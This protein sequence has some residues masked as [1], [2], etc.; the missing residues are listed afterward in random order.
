MN[1]KI[2]EIFKNYPEIIDSP[3]EMIEANTSIIIYEGQ[4]VIK[5][6]SQEII[7]DGV[8]QFDWFPN[9]GTSFYGKPHLDT[10]TLFKIFNGIDDFDVMLDG[11]FFGKGLL[12]NTS[13]GN[14][15]FI[16]GILSQ[17]AIKGDKSIAVQK[18][19]FSI[20]NLRDFLGISVKRVTDKGVNFSKNR[21]LLD[22]DNYTI[23]IDKCYNYEEL[24]QSLESKGGY[25]IQYAGELVSKKGSIQIDDAKDTLHCLDTF[26]SFLN[27]RRTSALFIH[28][29]YENETIWCD[30]TDYFVDT[31]KSNFSWPQKHS[32]I[33]INEL[34]QKF[35]DLWKDSDDKGFL[36]SAIHWYIEANSNSGFAEGSIIMAQTALELIYNWLIIE[37]K[38]ILIGKD[39]ENICAANKLRLILSH[40]NIDYN[41]PESFS[42]LQSFI[43]VSKDIIDAPDAVVQ[44]RNAIVHSQEEK[45]KK[46]S[47]IHYK[48]KYEALQL[49]IWYIEMSLLYILNFDDKYYNRCVRAIHMIDSEQFVPWTRKKNETNK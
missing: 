22:N 42:S 33:G 41:V 47:S 4:F 25:I 20:P 27:G 44:I 1:N 49:C 32:I 26:L 36:I 10:V 5:K 31:Y 13:F 8:I 35:S 39:S 18:L 21:L 7:I 24:Q 15:A 29:I 3:I 14:D 40:L 16:K 34:W 9:S 43:D 45:R 30:Y 2:E 11:L 23:T 38:K 12:T 48:A 17:K 6:D 37:N 28:G 19:R 46:L